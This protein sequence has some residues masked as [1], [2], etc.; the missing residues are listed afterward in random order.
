MTFLLS[1]GANNSNTEFKSSR[2]Y[3][4]SQEA[5]AACNNIS[6]PK[7][8]AFNGHFLY[9]F[10]LCISQ[11]D[12]EGKE[13]F[14]ATINMVKTLGVDGLDALTKILLFQPANK[15]PSKRLYPLL[16]AVSTFFTRHENDSW[17]LQNFLLEFKPYA[18]FDTFY[19]YVKMQKIPTVLGYIKPLMFGPFIRS[20]SS[21]LS[22][23]LDHPEQQSNL[24]KSVKSFLTDVNFYDASKDLLTLEEINFLSADLQQLCLQDWQTPEVYVQEMDCSQSQDAKKANGASLYREYFAQS[25]TQD[26]ITSLAAMLGQTSRMLFE[27]SENKSQILEQWKRSFHSLFKMQISPL[28][29]YVGLAHFFTRDLKVKDFEEII[30]ALEEI[31]AQTGPQAML[32]ANLK[33]GSAKIHQKMEDMMIE[34][35]PASSCPGVSLPALKSSQNPA[36]WHATYLEYLK[37]NSH[38]PY[39]LPVL[40]SETLSLISSQL[41]IN[42]PCS[43]EL[44]DACLSDNE[45]QFLSQALSENYQR[46]NSDNDENEN[47]KSVV[48]EALEFARELTR[49]NTTALYSLNLA[50]A[51]Y[52]LESLT[53]LIELIR[54]QTTIT[55]SLLAFYQE[56]QTAPGP[57][58]FEDLISWYVTY[59]SQYW[60][61]YNQL[62]D[63]SY[64]SNNKA[65]ILFQGLNPNGI[66]TRL[67]A[68]A[69]DPEKLPQELRQNIND[70][71][72][73]KV[74]EFLFRLSTPGALFKNQRLDVFENFTPWF[75]LANQSRSVEFFYKKKGREYEFQ[76][77]DLSKAP[78]LAKEIYSDDFW[79]LNALIP[80]D[81]LLAKDI[82]GQR[83][84]D[85]LLW[86]HQQFFPYLTEQFSWEDLTTQEL[87]PTSLKPLANHVRSTPYTNIE[88]KALALF[89]SQ[90]YMLALSALPQNSNSYKLEKSITTRRPEIRPQFLSLP[91][92]EENYWVTF[93]TN[94][95]KSFDKETSNIDELLNAWLTDFTED[96]WKAINWKNLPFSRQGEND[97]T[98][99]DGPHSQIVKVLSSLQLLAINSDDHMT[100]FLGIDQECLGKDGKQYNCPLTFVVTENKSAFANLKTYVKERSLSFLCPFL[101]SHKNILNQDEVDYFKNELNLKPN[102]NEINFCNKILEKSNLLTHDFSH[103]DRKGMLAKSMGQTL[104]EVLENGKNPQIASSLLSS[105]QKIAYNR[106]LRYLSSNQEMAKAWLNSQALTSQNEAQYSY[107]V[108]SDHKGL[109]LRA[110]GL[111]NNDLYF[112]FSLLSLKS[113]HYTK[114]VWRYGNNLKADQ[115]LEQGSFQRL[116]KEIVIKTYREIEDKE[117]PFLG[118]VYQVLNQLVKEE[119]APLQ[120]AIWYTLAYPDDIETLPTFTK[121][122]PLFL[123]HIYYKNQGEKLWTLAGP[124]L[125]RPLLLQENIRAFSLFSREFTPHQIKKFGQTLLATQKSFKNQNDWVEGLQL[126][127]TFLEQF[128]TRANQDG[129]VLSQVEEDL[130]K[131]FSTDLIV[132][133]GES[134]NQF[135]EILGQ[136]QIDLN[137]QE[138][139]SLAENLDLLFETLLNSGDHLLSLYQTRPDSKE[140]QLKTAVLG[141]IAPFKEGAQA[142]GALELKN[143][144]SLESTGLWDEVYYPLLYL[145]ESQKSLVKWLESTEKIGVNLA[146]EAA[147]EMPRALSQSYPSLNY[148]VE[149]IEWDPETSQDSKNALISL[150]FMAQEDNVIS[151]QQGQ[152]LFD[153]LQN[154]TVE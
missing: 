36:D 46:I 1:C 62:F 57:T 28:K 34:G 127:S 65:K 37:P 18:L 138:A 74:K 150:R 81:L 148:L 101:S 76:G 146:Q 154:K 2:S 16:R 137:S 4:K 140:D 24:H 133:E 32:S 97:L 84:D 107:K 86:A 63:N 38:C 29:H 82:H 45:L 11:Q 130:K 67:A 8:I 12:T 31:L 3:R 113:S 78:T 106:N 33:L 153:W 151:T 73:P 35:A 129:L 111:L 6:L 147:L 40:A 39:S 95:P 51:N 144:L 83:Q 143:L 109:Y 25:A 122:I 43:E 92:E 61:S 54:S 5:L 126:L 135:F 115:D 134:I 44:S 30:V 100:P 47:L 85:V 141:L 79:R 22:H 75:N 70:N 69:F 55:P 58:F 120:E 105:A 87:G 108:L 142:A 112:V 125:I 56:S 59:A 19:D 9:N 145:P 139:P 14:P 116:I 128:A 7:D 136:R 131:L 10:V 72:F 60:S 26:Q 64:S 20:I 99:P 71:D 124:R 13:K 80:E 96:N 110:P 49:K 89:F 93:L 132:R 102:Q 66:Y 48:L 117:Q 94:F 52:P 114:A 88:K 23:L 149:K 152:L 103:K 27:S 119:N 50:P 104:R 123:N 68:H 21:L 17:E 121:T 41:G 77:L 91:S 15:D 53:N 118:Y 98:W 90:N 42:Y